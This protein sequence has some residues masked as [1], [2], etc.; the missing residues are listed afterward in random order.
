MTSFRLH[1]GALVE[2][3]KSSVSVENVTDV[4]AVVENH[5]NEQGLTSYD[6]PMYIEYYGY[7]SR[8]EKNL[9]LVSLKHYG[10]V[11]WVEI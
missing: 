8:I 2:S 10:I 9:Y 1:A 11:G 6:Q 7:D 3:L 5:L 4:R